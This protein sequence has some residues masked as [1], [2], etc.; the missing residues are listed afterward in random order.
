MAERW[1][2]V[3]SIHVFGGHEVMLLRWMEELAGQ[4]R[5]EPHL[6]ARRG[7]RLSERGRA[8]SVAEGFAPA[9]SSPPAWKKPWAR[10]AN[11]CRDAA[12][13]IRAARRLKPSL[14][15]V[16]EG[17]LLSQA[18]FVGL[19]R[20]L[21]LR[22]AVYVPLVDSFAAMG[23]KR[24]G[25]KDWL[26]RW[27]YG[28][29]PQAW[30]TITGEQA[31][32]FARWAGVRRPV[33]ALP[34]TVAPAIEV[35]GDAGNTEREESDGPG[36][37]RILVLGR[38]DA[39]HKGLDLLFDHLEA[40][41]SSFPGIRIDLVGDGPYGAEIERRRQASPP[42]AR[43][44]SVQAWS[45]PVRAMAEHDV[46]LLPSRFEGV[47]LVMLE[48]MALGL[49]VVASDLPGTR[50]YLPEDCLFPIGDLARAFE[51]I[52]GLA[53]SAERAELAGRNRRVFAERASGTAF[54]AAVA[55]LTDKLLREVARP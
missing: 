13:F 8:W 2:F 54:A 19:A 53:S 12:V 11:P 17:C 32:G 1:L 33:F 25:L 45:D 15:V 36:P 28:N 43:R 6:L 24:A 41:P 38:L 9:E 29:L 4:G 20:L 39:H 30:I 18:L 35:R 42:L 16:A 23:L 50:A 5:V 7:C 46:L 40:D 47:P 3:D 27:V 44:V 48:A 49:P 52:R 26:M 34:N 10:L 21:G 37:L 31:E 22:V 14:C 55:G 51:I